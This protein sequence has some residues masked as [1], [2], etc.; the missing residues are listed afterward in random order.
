VI[1]IGRYQKFQYEAKLS[2]CFVC[3]SCKFVVYGIHHV[4]IQLMIELRDGVLVSKVACSDDE[5]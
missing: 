1:K 4:M 2:D 3:F 5:V